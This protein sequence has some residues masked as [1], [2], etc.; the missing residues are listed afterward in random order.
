M[1]EAVMI[2]G[3]IN[4]E[5][6]IAI[7]AFLN[8]VYARLNARDARVP[9][10]VAKKVAKMAINKLFR[11]PSFQRSVHTVVIPGSE[12][13]P[14]MIRYQ[15]SENASGSNRKNSGV[16]SRKGDFEKDSGITTTRGATRKNS[17]TAQTVR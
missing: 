7:S 5:I 15:R 1:P 12:Q 4:G 13:S 9:N 16:K 14:I 11:K 3:T 6:M 17:T 10:V 8:G 2:S